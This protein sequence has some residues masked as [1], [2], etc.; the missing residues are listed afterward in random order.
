MTA[1]ITDRIRI[2]GQESALFTEPLQPLLAERNLRFA[3]PHTALWRGYIAYWEI[4]DGKL[5]LVAFQGHSV[6]P[7]P[8]DKN[9][10]PQS[11]AARGR[12]SSFD[13]TLE[14]LFPIPMA[15]N[16]PNGSPA[17]SASPRAK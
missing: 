15:A 13:V 7:T 16:W 5:F 1:Q 3:S 6:A 11:T 17:P 4:A 14:N 10:S 8:S 9:E 12:R 2:D